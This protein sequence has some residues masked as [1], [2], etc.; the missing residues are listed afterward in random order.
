MSEPL[1][2]D[3]DPGVDDAIALLMAF[4]HPGA[5][6]LAV[7]G[8][9]GNVGLDRVMENLVHVL[10]VAGAPEIPV[11]AGCDRALL[12]D[13]RDAAGF[14]GTNGLGDV[15]VP[16]SLRPVSAEPAP[17][18]LARIVRDRPGEVTLLALGPLTNLAVAFA[19]APD[20]PGLLKRLV[21]MGGTIRGRGNV[22][23]AAEFNVW[24]DP[25]AAQRV[26]TSGA[27]I[28][29]VSWETTLDHAVPWPEWDAWTGGGTPRARFVR[30]ITRAMAEAGRARGDAGFLLPD[31]LAATVALDPAAVLEADRRAVAVELH[32]S[33]T[34]GQTLVDERP[35]ATAAANVTVVR[36]IDRD[37][38][39]RLVTAA[40]L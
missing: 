16:P 1:V 9:A 40:L 2:I 30:A 5:D 14:H 29:L 11:H 26:L 22:T 8:V 6:V 39:E 31:P 25:E 19:L 7:C 32:G 15:E 36:R 17:L 24:V 20:L 28:E 27:P 33:A 4:A 18:A 21:V 38:L 23:A 12:G 3:T 37:V 35:Q 34:R 13:R 10:D